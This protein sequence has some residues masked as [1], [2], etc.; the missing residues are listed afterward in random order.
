MQRKRY[1]RKHKY[2]VFRIFAAMVLLMVILGFIVT[3]RG[4]RL[5]SREGGRTAVKTSSE[6][7]K[8]KETMDRILADE[9]KYP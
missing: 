6:D 7:K 8:N 4:R 9:K 1:R 3:Q 2:N 5:D